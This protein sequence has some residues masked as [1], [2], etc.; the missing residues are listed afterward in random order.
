MIEINNLNY[1][2]KNG[3]TVLDNINLRIKTGETVSIIGKNGSGKSTLARLIA[4][5]TYPSSGEI[6]V[7][8]IDT[9]DKSKFYELRKT[10]RNCFSK[11]RKSNNF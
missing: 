9:K 1:K 11:S 8:D 5:I 3:D 10:I 2:Y 6:L 7:S 4:G